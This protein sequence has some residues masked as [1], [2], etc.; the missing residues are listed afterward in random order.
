LQNIIITGPFGGSEYL[1]DQIRLHF[2]VDAQRMIVRPMD[3]QSVV[4]RGA[5]TVGIDRHSARFGTSTA[6][7]TYLIQ[8]LVDFLPGL[9]SNLHCVQCL[10]G[11]DRCN[12]IAR[13]IVRKG[14][15]LD[16]PTHFR[17][18]ITKILAPGDPMVFYDSLYTYPQMTNENYISLHD[19][20]DIDE[21]G[22][23][24]HTHASNSKPN[25]DLS[26]VKKFGIIMT[27]LAHKR[28][29]VDFRKFRSGQGS[30]YNVEYHVVLT[31]VSASV[32]IKSYFGNELVGTVT[33]PYPVSSDKVR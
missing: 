6:Y 16:E 21:L 3:F 29:D 14:Q 17:V 27:N 10:D 30:F 7:H 15:V 5:V 22:K 4:A 8:I 18:A 28:P 2:P 26:G 12:D 9:H 13:V 24:L 33:I 20:P 32:I 11:Q 31:F 19:H 1:Y 25:S 23:Y